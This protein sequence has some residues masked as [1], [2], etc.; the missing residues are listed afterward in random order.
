MNYRSLH[1]NLIKYF[2]VKYI[3][4]VL[5]QIKTLDVIDNI[6]LIRTSLSG[7]SNDSIT[8]KVQKI[9][10]TIDSK[11]K[12][13]YLP[14]LFKVNSVTLFP[15]GIFVDAKGK[16][17][18]EVSL[19]L[20]HHFCAHLSN[21]LYA[22]NSNKFEALL[23]TKDC[24]IVKIKN[25]VFRVP[26]NPTSNWLH[27]IFEG[28]LP[29]ICNLEM[30]DKTDRVLIL[31]KYPKQLIELLQFI[32]F[33][34]FYKLD[35]NKCYFLESLVTLDSGAKIIDSL[36]GNQDINNFS[37]SKKA[38]LTTYSFF[39]KKIKDLD[40]VEKRIFPKKIAVL[41]KGNFRG[42]SN[43]Q[44]IE[45]FCVSNDFK[46]IYPEDE[47][48]LLQMLFFNR[49]NEILL[50]GG[51]AMAN[52]IFCKRG[53]KVTYLC[54]ETTANYQLTSMI[55]DS[56]G[57][58]LKIVPGKI[59]NLIENKSHSIYEFFHSSYSVNTKRIYPYNYLNDKKIPT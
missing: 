52:L 32:G 25:D 23:Y 16:L 29:L 4:H 57:L 26:C 47:T 33:K 50:E 44:E 10:Y 37:I 55:C 24:E 36:A 15:Q 12:N 9:T 3:L 46:L 54:S 45:A 2:P 20:R 19:D 13:D 49:A 17:I 14:S 6:A 42:L 38:L 31:H 22:S 21:H 7:N 8:R 11:S 53:T 59:S 28:I 43:R 39:Q 58:K 35:E 51:A 30:I 34:S 56:L 1:N 41:R 48:F 27:L 40:S 18:N 5:D